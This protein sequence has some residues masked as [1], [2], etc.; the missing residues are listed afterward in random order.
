MFKCSL[1]ALHAPKVS[2][3]TSNPDRP[4]VTHFI[5]ASKASVSQ[6]PKL[7]NDDRCTLLTPYFC[8][9]RHFNVYKS[10]CQCLL[11]EI[12]IQTVS[13]LHPV[14]WRLLLYLSIALIKIMFYRFFFIFFLGISTSF[15]DAYP[16]TSY[17]EMVKISNV[18]N[19]WKTLSLSNS[20]TNPVVACT[21]NLPSNA[22]NE[23][24]VRVQVVGSNIQVKVQRPLNSSSVT[25]S[26]V[27]CT[28]SEEGSYTS[29][30]KYEAHTIVS[31]QTNNKTAWQLSRTENV[32]GTKVQTYV[33]PVVTG[34]VMTYNNPNFVSF[35]SNRCN[36][37]NNA[38]YETGICVGKHTGESSISTPTTETLGYFIAEA[39]E[40]SLANA[41]VKIQLGGD[42]IR[43]VSSAPPYNYVLP[44]SYS[45][46]TATIA[47]MDGGDGGWA[48]LYGT[49]P[50]STNINLAIDED[51]VGDSERNHTTEQVA[52]WVMEPIL[53]VYANLSFNEVMYRQGGGKL[54]SIELSV[55]SNGTILNYIVS[56]QDGTGQNYSLPDIDVST[57]D[58]VVFYSGAGTNNSAGG[59]HHIY[60]QGSTTVLANTGDDIVL[61]KPSSTD[62]T[63]LNGSSGT[64]NGIPVDYISYGT[65]ASIDAVPVSTNGVTVSWNNSD[66]ARLGGTAVGE[67]ISLTPNGNDTDTSVC[68]ERTTSG[69]ASACTSFIITHDSDPSSHLNS[70]GQNNTLAPEI[71]LAKTVLTIFDPYNGASNPKAIPGAILE[72]NIS[73]ENNGALAA[74]N[75]SINISDLIPANTKLCVSNVGN[76]TPPY[77]VNGS[78]SSGMSLASTA[79]SN[80]GGATYVYSASGD[81]EGA[82]E[83]VTNLR[84]VMNGAFQPKT[85][86]TAPSFSL[87]FRVVVK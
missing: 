77:F 79:Y 30:I 62:T 68:W 37:K 39:A 76:C 40:Y 58:Y 70:L 24:A 35:W 20:Y 11:S 28:I 49:S 50:I 51:T 67:S 61:L 6:K 12:L 75:N 33:K 42:S 46:A 22:S 69:D 2:Q 65:G 43:G 34:Q 25:A 16:I 5:L 31:A 29:P 64:F 21:Y 57:G 26:D 66:I 3:S 72:Y 74:D 87:K 59:V 48:V 13:S 7:S 71:T 83:N 38:P 84:A 73:A 81:A 32:T 23:G 80:N 52:Y 4:Q 86:A 27:Y 9:L 8:Y 63:V 41:Y 85:G 54:E 55:L 60:S 15:L 17:L 44:R 1:N 53:K 78:P 45:Y 47:A 19:A 10:S 36:S 18:S 82:D 14:Q 56:S